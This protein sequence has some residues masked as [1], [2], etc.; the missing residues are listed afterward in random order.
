MCTPQGEHQL[1]S[2]L[3]GL[4]G[5]LFTAPNSTS[6]RLLAA[7]QE[8]KNITALKLRIKNAKRSV[9]KPIRRKDAMNA[10]YDP[11]FLKD[12]LVADRNRVDD[13]RK[14]KHFRQNKKHSAVP[15]QV[16]SF[17]TQRRTI[18]PSL[19]QLTFF[20]VAF[21]NPY[22]KRAKFAVQVK[23]P[24]FSGYA[25][26]STKDSGS[27]LLTENSIPST[28]ELQLVTDVNEWVFLKRQYGLNTPT[29]VN[30]FYKSPE[31]MKSE[32]DN[33]GLSG[34]QLLGGSDA[35]K[36]PNS[37]V[38]IV[39][40]RGETVYIPFKYQ[41]FCAGRIPG[42]IIVCVC[43]CVCDSPCAWTYLFLYIQCLHFVPL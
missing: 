36:D 5:S 14:I 35:Q 24:L 7:K 13:L 39:L 33:D 37:R 6:T 42:T 1:A 26:A 10:S 15:T 16:R 9:P 12:R 21:T 3:Q 27:L 19:G 40:D 38:Y 25:T 29:K 32:R 11:D 30:M 41:S 8:G 2:E 28:P 17:I 20:E 43:V 4:E 31:D 18:N 34:K 22:P 23:D